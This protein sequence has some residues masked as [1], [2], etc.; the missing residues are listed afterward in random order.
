MIATAGIAIR[1]VDRAHRNGIETLVRAVDTAAPDE[2]HLRLADVATKGMADLMIAQG[3]EAHR[4]T[5]VPILRRWID[6]GIHTALVFLRYSNQVGDPEL[7]LWALENAVELE[8]DNGRY[9]YW[10]GNRYLDAGR[11]DEALEQ[12]QRARLDLPEDFRSVDL[13]DTR[14]ERAEAGRAAVPPR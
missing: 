12:L 11:Y 13:L 8:P 14:I 2:H 10:L 6:N 9:R 7:S 3:E 1:S 5:F 4:G